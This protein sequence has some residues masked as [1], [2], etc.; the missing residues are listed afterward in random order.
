MIRVLII[1]A[2]LVP[3]VFAGCGSSF[4]S[5]GDIRARLQNEDPSVRVYAAIE[6]GNTKRQDV[7]PLLVDRLTDRDSNVRMFSAMALRK[8]TGEDFGWASWKTLRQ[9]E[10]SV[11]R[12]RQWLKK[13]SSPVPVTRSD[14]GAE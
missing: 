5:E 6:A 3:A 4:Q 14:N 12:W 9:R 2:G 8:I 1:V 11:A 13:H 7:L 10:E